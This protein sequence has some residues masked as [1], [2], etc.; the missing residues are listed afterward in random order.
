MPHA[1]NIPGRLIL[2][3][4]LLALSLQ[5]VLA[6]LMDGASSLLTI[7]TRYFSLLFQAE[8]RPAAEYLASF[9]DASYEEIT[10]LLACEP[11]F[12]RF[13][14]VITPEVDQ[15][16]G[17]YTNYPYPRIV[18]YQ[19]ATDANGS[20]AGFDNDLFK[21]FYHELTHAVS[22]SQRGPL[23]RLLAGL[24]GDPFS[25]NS[26]R[27]PLNLVEGITVAF[28]SRNGFG[29]ASDPFAGALLRQDI[30]EGEWKSFYQTTGVYSAWPGRT[31][32]YIY[33]G[34]FSKMLIDR[35]GIERYAELWQ[36]IGSD[37][38]LKPFD[39]FLF[40]P[41]HF[42]EVYG[43]SLDQA[44]QE[45]K[46]SLTISVPVLITP[47]PLR[48]LSALGA[49]AADA[50]RLY[51]YDRYRLT[52]LTMDPVS[53]REEALLDSGQ[54]ITRI[55]VHPADG[56]LLLSTSREAGQLSRLALASL[57]ADGSQYRLLPWENLRDASWLD[58]DD[59]LAIEV[60]GYQ[61]NLVRTVGQTVE[62]LLAGSES[63]SYSTPVLAP[64]GRVY[65][66]IRQAGVN[67]I[68]RLRLPISGQAVDGSTI[69]RLNLPAG[70][71]WLRYL[72]LHGNS[73]YAAWDD[74]KLARLLIVDLDADSVGWQNV[75]LSG[76][77][78]Q[79]VATD[80]GTYHLSQFSSGLSLSAWTDLDGQ[81][82]W[83]RQPATWQA[84]SALAT[85]ASAYDRPAVRETVPYNA[86]W[87]LLPRFWHPTLTLNAA[88]T[89]AGAAVYFD[90]PIE[91]LDALLSGSWNFS[92][93]APS[94]SLN[95]VYSGL[96]AQLG[97]NLVDSHGQQVTEDGTPYIERLSLALLQVADSA[98]S[99]AGA[100]FAWNALALVQANDT[101]AIGQSLYR[102]WAT[103][104][105]G[106]GTSLSLSRFSATLGEPQARSGYRLSASLNGR[107]R[108]FP[109]DN[110]TRLS[111]NTA[112][113]LSFRPLA[114]QTSLS[115]G[116]SALAGFDDDAPSA[117]RVQPD[118][119][120]S[121]LDAGL[122]LLNVAL[123]R[124]TGRLY[125]SSLS[126]RAG[127]Y[128]QLSS[129]S[130]AP[131]S[132]WP[133]LDWYLYGRLAVNWSPLIG[134]VG[135]YLRPATSLEVRYRPLTDS[136]EFS[137]SL[138]GGY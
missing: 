77:V 119:W 85:T 66:L 91:R 104:D 115:V 71:P 33:G 76:G 13:P 75:P 23:Q 134:G 129:N 39:S 122:Q 100:V 41:G 136:Y 35:Y 12:Q 64:D 17:Y 51:Y 48:P 31:L 1:R 54:P 8:S 88:G 30:L 98:A 120:Y 27:T 11:V 53:G 22:L 34:Y 67:S 45:L 97:L 127:S 38:L 107:Y 83:R 6:D 135:S 52:L 130:S 60:D 89:A 19:A 43:F 25:L 24:F 92:V 32:F 86:A 46:D 28:E 56:R 57:A 101:L 93:A 125:Y 108:L 137:L 14:V 112:F 105:A 49:L 3:C 29:R 40:S 124:Q 110:D 58:A 99:Q 62:R 138:V 63:V 44:W 16:N 20:L 90:D 121:A 65:C 70:I 84:A 37:N 79:P 96:P 102:P 131:F 73:L 81:T 123:E 15:V 72:S 106:L 118:S 42:F 47:R 133:D 117:F 5:P 61:T 50:K 109:L 59:I 26:L 114:I 103:I 36:R 74:D 113:G 55:A 82:G 94:F 87:W 95:L 111:L 2:L 69:E 10:S 80:S 21:L 18:L 4:Y 132:A 9:A 126:A 116:L 78:H 7:E 68:V 128:T